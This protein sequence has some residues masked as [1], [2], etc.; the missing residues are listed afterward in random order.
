[1]AAL[2]DVANERRFGRTGVARAHAMGKTVSVGW[3]LPVRGGSVV[4][5]R[6]E[7]DDDGDWQ[8]GCARKGRKALGCFS[9]SFLSLFVS[10]V[11]QLDDESL[12]L[13]SVAFAL[14]GLAPNIY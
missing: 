12:A 13:S 3:W 10:L 14:V 4:S 5:A 2:E 7:D 1:V 8:L 6:D 11:L 9:S